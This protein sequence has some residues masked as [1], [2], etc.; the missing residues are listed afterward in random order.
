VVWQRNELTQSGNGGIEISEQ[1][2]DEMV[3]EMMAAIGM[4]LHP[5]KLVEEALDGLK[6]LQ[7]IQMR[8]QFCFGFH[9]RIMAWKNEGLIKEK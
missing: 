6:E 3:V 2:H 1:K 9:A 4:R 7:A 8:R 5:A